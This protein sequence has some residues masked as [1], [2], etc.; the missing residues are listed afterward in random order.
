MKNT[1]YILLTGVT[2]AIGKATV[3]ELVKIGSYPL[4]LVGRNED[5]LLQLLQEVQPLNPMVPIRTLR[6]D[7]SDLEAVNAGIA[8]IS[9]E[10]K[11]LFGIINLAAVITRQRTLVKGGLE[12]MFATNYLGPFLLT[13]QLSKAFSQAYPLRIITVSSASTSPIDFANLQGEN[14]FSSIAN[15]SKSKTCN[16]LFVKRL[17]REFEGTLSVSLGFDPGIVRSKAMDEMPKLFGLIGKLVGRPPQQAARAL[18]LLATEPTYQQAN[19]Q[20]FNKHLK[21]V[22]MSSYADNR[23][24]QDEL[25]EVSRRKVDHLTVADTT[26]TSYRASNPHS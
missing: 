6:L 21:T 17:A 18:A 26:Q 25:W 7:L 9:E 1:N 10:Y 4:L 12:T 23:Q 5:S 8:R 16:V 19:G 11:G 13:S 24:I 2:G 20:F 15:F 14:R 22:K 3:A